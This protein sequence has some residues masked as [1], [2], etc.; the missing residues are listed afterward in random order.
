[1][2]VPSNWWEHFFEGLAVDLWLHALPPEYTKSEAER[3]DRLLVVEPGAE[4]LDVPCGAGRLSLVLASRGYRMTGV[5]WS[6]EFLGHARTSAGADAVAW[7]QRDMRDLPWLGRFDGA[8]CVGN[9]FGYLD[10]DGNL[11]FLKAVRAA[12]K[13][14]ARFVVETPMLIE[15]LFG[16]L[17]PRPWWKSGGTYLFVENA[18]DHARSR[19]DI[20]YTFMCDGRVEVRR[21]SHR[22]YSYR[23]LSDLI[24]SAGFDVK[25]GEPWTREAHTVSFVATRV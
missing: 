5:D 19:L 17:Q 6:S 3:L 22:A 21:G 23:E 15:N 4:L 16:H 18:Y 1:V 11:A 12:L 2:N 20:E 10:D 13:P 7:E 8:F 24:G 9:S 14:G 25:P